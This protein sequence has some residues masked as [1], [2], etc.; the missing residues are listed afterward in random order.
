MD[1]R[2]VVVQSTDSATAI[3]DQQ[4]YPKLAYSR[5]EAA[6]L[7]SVSVRTIDN[8]VSNGELKARRTGKRV[9]ITHDAVVQFIRRDHLTTKAKVQ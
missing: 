4:I 7:L 9:L 2:E 6:N 1:I 8:L 5:D 3:S